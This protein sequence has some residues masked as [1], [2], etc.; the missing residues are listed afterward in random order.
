M[1]KLILGSVKDTNGNQ[2]DITY[3][4]VGYTNVSEDLFDEATG[5]EWA[6]GQSNICVCVEDAVKDL[7]G[8]K[9]ESVVWPNLSEDLLRLVTHAQKQ[10]V[11]DLV[12]YVE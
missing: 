2:L 4:L 7:E 5:H 9:E 6:Y 1:A 12:L 3:A 10:G 8:A 11:G